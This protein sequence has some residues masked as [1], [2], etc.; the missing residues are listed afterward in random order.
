MPVIAEWV[1][2]LQFI[3]FWQI[4]WLSQKTGGLNLNGTVPEIGYIRKLPT[5]ADLANTQ[6]ISK[7]TFIRHPGQFLRN[8]GRRAQDGAGKRSSPDY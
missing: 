5:L 6:K 2:T 1:L 8:V 4:D 3:I 7:P